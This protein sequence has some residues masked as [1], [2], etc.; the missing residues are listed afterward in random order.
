M[1]KKLKSVSE[2]QDGS[3]N[4]RKTLKLAIYRVWGLGIAAVR[5][6]SQFSCSD[7]IRITIIS[8]SR[9]SNHAL[10]WAKQ[11]YSWS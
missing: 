6:L 10:E 9:G 8:R 5:F 1:L 7:T 2:V 4:H 3:A 11:L